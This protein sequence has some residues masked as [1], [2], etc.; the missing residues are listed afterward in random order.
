MFAAGT[1]FT[2]ALADK[3]SKFTNADGSALKKKT[4]E[5]A[6]VIEEPLVKIQVLITIN[7][8]SALLRDFI[9]VS[10]IPAPCMHKNQRIFHSFVE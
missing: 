8:L 2:A 9:A 10:H 6:A 3:G 5:M 7:C 4:D 1:K